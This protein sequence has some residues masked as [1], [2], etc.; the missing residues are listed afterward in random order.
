MLQEQLE[1][2]LIEF[3]TSMKK[4]PQIFMPLMKQHIKQVDAAIRNGLIFIT[5]SSLNHD[6]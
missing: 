2:I 1:Y 6:V 4:I 3:D 5:W